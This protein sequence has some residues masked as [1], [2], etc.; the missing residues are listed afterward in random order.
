MVVIDDGNRDRRSWNVTA[1]RVD[2]GWNIVSGQNFKGGD[3]SRFGKGVGVFAN[4]NRSVNVLG[5]AVLNDGLRDC[6][7]VVVVERAIEGGASVA[8]SA[9]RNLLNRI[10]HIGLD[11]EIIVHQFFNVY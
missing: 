1:S 7:N 3:F 9:K 10:V 6:S 5:S 8:R 4:V 11:G 2:Q